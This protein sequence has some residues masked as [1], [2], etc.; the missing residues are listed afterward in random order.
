MIDCGKLFYPKRN[1]PHRGYWC[2]SK[3]IVGINLCPKCEKKCEL[4]EEEVFALCVKP[5]GGEQ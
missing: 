1:P 2:G 4:S 5:V 3:G